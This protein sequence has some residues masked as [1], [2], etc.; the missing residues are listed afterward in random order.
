MQRGVLLAMECLPVLCFRTFLKRCHAAQLA[1]GG[2]ATQLKLS[3]IAAAAA[4]VGAEDDID[5][6]QVCEF[7]SGLLAIAWAW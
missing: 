2:H 4:A 5:D 3:A 6:I 1:A 7:Q